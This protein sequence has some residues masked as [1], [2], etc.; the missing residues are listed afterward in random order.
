MSFLAVFGGFA[1]NWLVLANSK[2][3]P[4]ED[5]Y[6]LSIYMIFIDFMNPVS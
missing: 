1:K 5:S 6:G 3:V 2:M 4:E